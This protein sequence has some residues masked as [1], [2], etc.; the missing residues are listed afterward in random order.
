MA[1][2]YSAASLSVM[3]AWWV[4][5]CSWPAA[6]WW[7]LRDLTRSACIDSASKCITWAS[8]WSIQ[9]TAW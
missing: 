6:R 9:T 4:S 8:F 2:K 5:F 7:W 1:P 3:P